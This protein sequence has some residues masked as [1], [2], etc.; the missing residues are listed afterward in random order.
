LEKGGLRA[1]VSRAVAA[2]YEKSL[3]LAE[4]SKK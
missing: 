1:T 3:E 2:C 4:M